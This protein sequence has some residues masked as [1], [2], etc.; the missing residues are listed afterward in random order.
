MEYHNPYL[1]LKMK[2]FLK[3][4]FLVFLSSMP[5]FGANP[6][7]NTFDPNQFNVN[8]S[9]NYIGIK[10][11]GLTNMAGGVWVWQSNSVAIFC[12]TNAAALG[13]AVYNVAKNGDTVYIGPGKYATNLTFPSGIALQGFGA[14]TYDTNVGFLNGTI[15]EGVF[16]STN[17]NTIRGIGFQ[18]GTQ[19][20]FEVVPSAPLNG[21]AWSNEVNVVMEDCAFV[22]TNQGNSHNIFVSGNGGQFR[23]LRSINSGGHGYAFK[24]ITN[25]VMEDLYGLN[26]LADTLVITSATN[27]GGLVGNVYIR[28]IVGL[29]GILIVSAGQGAQTV[30][31]T[32]DG[33]K[34]DSTTGAVGIESQTGALL[35]NITIRGID[36][37][38]AA[39]A[40]SVIPGGTFS[41]IKVADTSIEGSA[42]W[43][44]APGVT[45]YSPF[46]AVNIQNGSGLVIQGTGFSS[47]GTMILSTPSPTTKLAFGIPVAAV[48]TNMFVTNGIAYCVFSNTLPLGNLFVGGTAILTNDPVL[49]ASSSSLQ[50]VWA[51][52][53]GGTN[54][55][56]FVPGGDN[57]LYVAF[58]VTNANGS[59][60]KTN[61]YFGKVMAWIPIVPSLQLAK[62]DMWS[63]GSIS[64]F[65]TA[66]ALTES[67]WS[68]AYT[69]LSGQSGTGLPLFCLLKGPL[70]TGAGNG[71]GG[72]TDFSNEYA[73]V[74]GAGVFPYCWTTTKGAFIGTFAGKFTG[75][76][77]FLY[78]NFGG[79][80]NLQLDI[81]A[82]C[83]PGT[84]IVQTNS[85]W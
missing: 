31:V 44:F 45:D 21:N 12:G 10:G 55:P 56:A 53:S 37:P 6:T 35:Q 39:N 19:D 7:F 50:G 63:Q 16:T 71:G 69:F 36:A 77:T 59:Y 47:R 49:V 40:V 20:I 54:K 70:G 33:G 27:Q 32:I 82:D 42:A 85:W 84:T 76:S 28:G 51:Y 80:S 5:A 2:H 68:K 65:F 4:I 22:C 14:G 74:A 61:V 41:H 79:M 83:P 17:G 29:Q 78:Q 81:Y 75:G 67:Y 48:T 58:N 72:A 9:G 18:G 43:S 38:H 8:Q 15:L 23:R 13:R 60:D 66:G 64:G 57:D 26:N 30:D 73:T 25:I 46:T 11:A 24:G 3:L 34:T 52:N 62:I 1:E